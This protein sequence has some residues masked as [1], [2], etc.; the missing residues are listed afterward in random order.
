MTMVEAALI[1]GVAVF[2]TLTALLSTVHCSRTMTRLSRTDRQLREVLNSSSDAE[3]AAVENVRLAA[4]RQREAQTERAARQVA[5]SRMREAEESREGEQDAGCEEQDEAGVESE[6]GP[7]RVTVRL[8][9]ERILTIEK[10]TAGVWAGNSEE[11]IWSV[12][13]EHIQ[14][15][16]YLRLLQRKSSLMCGV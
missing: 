15:T 14:G 16:V 12:H 13:V 3:A 9:D 8:G 10:D 1:S 5:E 7:H 11:I 6:T 4:A 2:V